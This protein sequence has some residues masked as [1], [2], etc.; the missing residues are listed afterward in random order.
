MVALCN[1]SYWYICHS[2]TT[3]SHILE[4]PSAPVNVTLDTTT[5]TTVLIT[6]DA[7]EDTDGLPVQ[8]YIA[9]LF[10]TNNDIPEEQFRTMDNSTSIM[11]TDL[12]P[13]LSYTVVVA[14]VTQ[15]LERFFEGNVSDP[16]TFITMNG[17]KYNC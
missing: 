11:I 16:I 1:C 9:Y 12:L 10:I 7:P 2:F 17:R 15:R 5:N 8:S 13:A 3:F 14:A 6:W 4:L